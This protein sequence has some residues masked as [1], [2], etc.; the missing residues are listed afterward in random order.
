MLRRALA[1]MRASWIHDYPDDAP[2]TIIATPAGVAAA[3][4]DQDAQSMHDAL[5]VLARVKDDMAKQTYIAPPDPPVRDARKGRSGR[6]PLGVAPMSSAERSERW[7]DRVNPDR[8]RRR[9]RRADADQGSDSEGQ[10]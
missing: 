5:C 1:W 3:E 8:Q 7:R 10:A 4:N 2:I 9:R 6:K